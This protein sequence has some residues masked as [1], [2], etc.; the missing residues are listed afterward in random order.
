MTLHVATPPDWTSALSSPRLGDIVSLRAPRG[1]PHW[2]KLRHLDPPQGL[3]LEE[4]WAGIK[5]ARANVAREIPLTD[6]DGLPFSYTTPDLV[7]SRLHLVD[8]RCAGEIKMPEV[9]TGDAQ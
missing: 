3:T 4:W 5:F 6:I 9:V 8:Q 2:D 1:Y 7:L